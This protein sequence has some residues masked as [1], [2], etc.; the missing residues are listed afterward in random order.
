[1]RLEEMYRGIGYSPRRSSCAEKVHYLR[2][3]DAMKAA[4]EHEWEVVC[5]GMNVYR[6]SQHVCWH[7]GHR[8]KYRAAALALME[9]VLWF[10]AW[11]DESKA[12]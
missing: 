6:C 8:D 12:A 9:D 1:M 3:A 7:I 5:I 11:S 2:K 10:M 4:S